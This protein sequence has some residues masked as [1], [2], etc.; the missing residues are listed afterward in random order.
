MTTSLHPYISKF[1]EGFDVGK[2]QEYRIAI[3]FTLGGFSY[4]IMDA[5][6]NVIVAMESYLSDDLTDEKDIF[7][8]FEKA[9]A[10]NKLNGKKFQSVT[11]IIGNR[12]YAL[13]PNELFDEKESSKYLGFLH[14]I[15]QNG[16]VLNDNLSENECH[17][18]Y[19][20]SNCLIEKIKGIWPDAKIVH[21]SS[22]FLRH[23]T[24]V[25]NLF[26]TTRVYVYVK[27]R[28]FDMAIFKNGNLSFFNNFKFNTKDDFLYFLMF[29]IEQQKMSAYETSVCVSGMILGSSEIMKLCERY[30]KDIRFIKNGDT[31]KVSEALK[32]IPSQYYYI[33]YQVLQCES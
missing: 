8:T 33:P 16:L 5:G 25:A 30:I 12:N 20:V 10:L 26:A 23:I 31:I 13:I 15:P 4:L 18:I 22:I 7:N 29:A 14:T 32:E 3:Q 19:S 24:K 11:C 1:D 6:T 9:L 21:E 28:S 2:T 27:N 17:G